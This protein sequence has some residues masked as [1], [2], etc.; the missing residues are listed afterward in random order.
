MGKVQ[1]QLFV[2]MT[3][4]SGGLIGVFG[5]KVL[6]II[7]VPLLLLWFGKYDNKKFEEKEIENDRIIRN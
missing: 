2:L 6:V 7:F 3:L 5:L 4:V 1:Q